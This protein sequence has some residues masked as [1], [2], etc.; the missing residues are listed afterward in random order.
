MGWWA[1]SQH[2]LGTRK[3][4]IFGPELPDSCVFVEGKDGYQKLVL[5]TEI[6]HL[7]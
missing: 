4:S 1:I 6:Q 7:K 2:A 3:G 5:T